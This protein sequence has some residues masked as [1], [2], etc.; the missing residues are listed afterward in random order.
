MA[1]SKY[2]WVYMFCFCHKRISRLRWWAIGAHRLSRCGSLYFL[3]AFYLMLC[4]CIVICYKIQPQIGDGRHLI[5]IDDSRDEELC[6]FSA[7]AILA[8]RWN[9]CLKKIK[10]VIYL[11]TFWGG[12]YCFSYRHSSFF[13]GGIRSTV[14]AIFSGEASM[15]S[16]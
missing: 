15:R 4:L 13:L 16:G 3:L 1:R 2:S 5:Y 8:D 11:C 7:L 9:P 14:S 12:D 10:G 6:I